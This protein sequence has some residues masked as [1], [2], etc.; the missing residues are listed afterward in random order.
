MKCA[1]INLIYNDHDPDFINILISINSLIKSK[2][3]HDFILMYTLDVPQYKI[4]ILKKYFTK[5]IRVE[6][7]I[8]KKHPFNHKIMDKCTKFQIFNM[9][10]YEKI[11][12]LNNELFIRKNIDGLFDCKS[13][14]GIVYQNILL[15]NTSI[16]IIKPSKTIYQKLLKLIDNFDNIKEI[17]KM[18]VEILNQIFRKWNHIPKKYNFNYLI[19]EYSDNISYLDKHSYIIDFNYI[20]YP[21]TILKKIKNNHL[22]KNQEF[23]RLKSL[24]K[25]WFQNYIELYHFYKKKGIYL[26]HLYGV[27]E[28]N[29]EH[30]IFEK[31]PNTKIIK[32]DHNQQ[33]KLNQK[34]SMY[35]DST[36]KYTY[37]QIIH[38]FLHHHVPLFTYGGTVRGLFNDEK[39]K[40]LDLLYISSYQK[41]LELLLDINDLKFRQGNFKKYF[42]VGNEFDL[43][44]MNFDIIKN[45]LNSPCNGLLYDFKKKQVYDLTGNGIKDASQKIWR[46][47]PDQSFKNWSSDLQPRILRLVKFLEK[48][49]H[50]PLKD[51]RLIYEDLYEVKKDRSYWF[52]FKN[53]VN[54]E[55]YN[56]LKKDVDEMKLSFTGQQMVDYI[57]KNVQSMNQSSNQSHKNNNKQNNKNNKQNNKN[58]KQNNKNN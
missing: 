32:L 4:D 43:E 57:K 21:D 3:K 18:D 58:N 25:P 44:F 12:F 48:G 36:K 19:K 2:T 28:S 51:K 13:P 27:I 29:Y 7:I 33:S 55:F 45:V 23:M 30:Y 15:A 20:P 34:L 10:E 14:A 40:D 11:I 1:Y 42:K 5:I 46:L 52:F 6:Y 56:T 49:Y 50:I 53:K 17:W 31:F 16:L 24:Y 8:S 47:S 54:N 41:I 22:H 39:I 9:I 37:K 38:Y 26:N 35:I